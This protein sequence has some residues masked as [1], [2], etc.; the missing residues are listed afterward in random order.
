MIAKSPRSVQAYEAA[1]RLRELERLEKQGTTRE[2]LKRRAEEQHQSPLYQHGTK[3]LARGSPSYPPGPL[4]AG[5]EGLVVVD[6]EITRDGGVRDIVV[7]ESDPPFL[8][9]GVALDAVRKWVYQPSDRNEPR[10]VTV[11]F[12]FGIAPP[13]DSPTPVAG[14]VDGSTLDPLERRGRDLF[15]NVVASNRAYNALM[16]AGQLSSLG[17]WIVVPDTNRSLVRYIDDQGRVFADVRV[18]VFSSELEQVTI[19]EVP[20]P[21]PADQYEIWKARVDALALTK[22]RRVT[23]CSADYTSVVLPS[24][25]P[26]RSWDVYLL[27]L[28]TSDRSVPIGGFCAVTARV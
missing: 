3:P 1:L 19:H 4:A 10:R 13:S 18:D 14:R 23:G 9:E 16:R 28:S 6:F 27:S 17:N 15:E 2:E 25:E 20:I 11:R 5:I 22:A 8:F 24:R 12:P 26:D 21:L 7:L